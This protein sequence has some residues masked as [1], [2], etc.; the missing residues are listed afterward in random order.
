MHESLLKLAGHLG[1]GIDLSEL[2]GALYAIRAPRSL[3]GII[4]MCGQ[5]QDWRQKYPALNLLPEVQ[6]YARCL[7]VL[8]AIAGLS[9]PDDHLMGRKIADIKNPWTPLFGLGGDSVIGELLLCQRVGAASSADF[10]QVSAWLIW[11]AQRFHARTMSRAAYETYLMS[12]TIRLSKRPPG[13]RLYEAWL[14]MR[15]LAAPGDS[16]RQKLRELASLTMHFSPEGSEQLAVLFDLG[17]RRMARR[18]RERLLQQAAAW[19]PS[20]DREQEAVSAVKKIR[21]VMPTGIGRLLSLLWVDRTRRSVRTKRWRREFYGRDRYRPEIIYGERL[22]ELLQRVDA[23]EVHAGTVVEFYPRQPKPRGGRSGSGESAVDD[24]PEDLSEQ[25]PQLSIFLADGKELIRGYYASEGQQNGVEYGNAMLRWSNWTLSRSAIVAVV[26]LVGAPTSISETQLDRCARLAIGLTLLTGRSLERVGNFEIAR[27]TP[28]VSKKQPVMIGLRAH[29][30]YLYPGEPDLRHPPHETPPLCHP[31]ANALSL[32]LPS[33]WWALVEAI[34]PGNRM[35]RRRVVSR[36]RRALK[37]LGGKSGRAREFRIT[38]RG[39]RHAFIRAL[40]ERTRGDLGA[41]Q[42][43]TDDGAVNARNIIHYASYHARRLESQWRAA[44]ESLVGVLPRGVQGSGRNRYVGAQHAFD[45]SKLAKY[46]RSIKR[47]AW[48]AQQKNDWPRLFNLMTLYLS[49]WLGL[50]VAGR[51]TL[52]PVP[53][54]LIDD[55]WALVMDKH[56]ID[57]STDRLVP[58]SGTLRDQIDA[59]V[60]FAS[61]LSITAPKLDPIVRTERG[62]E[63]RLQYI[64][65]VKGVVPYRPKY[66]ERHEHL[67]SLPANWGRKVLRSVSS[68]LPGRYRDAEMGHWVRGRHAWDATS[69]FDAADFRVSWL[70]LQTRMEKRLGFK[71]IK[72]VHFW[73]RDRLSPLRP[74]TSETKTR[75]KAK[76]E[77][78]SARSSLGAPPPS[79]RKLDIVDLLREVDAARAGALL[80]DKQQLLPV[81]ALDLVRR[82]VSSQQRESV[83]WQREVAEAACALVRD[84]KQIP[85]FAAKPRPLF[86]NKVVLSA[87]ALQT[88]AYM[89][90]RVL[91]PFL[92]DLTCLPTRTP[93]AVDPSATSC[94]DSLRLSRTADQTPACKEAVEGGLRPKGEEQVQRDPADVPLPLN[95][96]QADTAA[97]RVK[98]KGAWEIELGRLAMV[99]IWRLGL[100]RWRLIE[101]WLRSVREDAPVLAQGPNR[102]MVVQV[103]TDG[104][105]E[106]VRRTVFLDAFTSSY[107]AADR[108]WVRQELLEPLFHRVTPA[109]RRARVGRAVQAY[110]RF[111]GAGSHRITLSAMTAAAAQKIMLDSAPILAAYARGELHTWDLGDD[112]LRRLAKLEPTRKSRA[113]AAMELPNSKQVEPS[114]E[115]VPLKLL[116]VKV[117]IAQ[118]LRTHRSNYKS[119]WREV[120]APKATTPPAEAL[121]RQFAMWMVERAGS[122]SEYPRLSAH[123]RRYIAG[124]VEVV[125]FAVLGYATWDGGA[126]TID[127]DVLLELQEASR[128]EFPERLQHGAWFQFDR[129]LGDKTADH[130]GFEVE[131]LGPH[132]ERAVS[133]KILRADELG[134]IHAALISSRSNIGNAELRAS[135]Q[136]NF[137]LMATYGTRRS[138]SAYLRT[139]DLQQDLCRVQV[140]D[141][142]RLKTGWSDRVLP[143]DFAEGY[144]QAWMREAQRRRYTF[145]IDPAAGTPANPDNFFDK[146]NQLVKEVTGDISMGSHHL[147]HTLASR[148]VLTLLRK[149]AG[150]D[151]LEEDLPWIKDLMI[152]SKRRMHALLGAEG[153][154]GQGMR[155]VSA[156]VGHSHPTT[157]IRHYVHV[158]G[159]ALYGALRKTD[160][161]DISRSFENRISGKSTVQRW[162]MQA[163]ASLKDEGNAESQRRAINRAMR[164]RIEQRFHGKG[165]DYDETPR[166]EADTENAASD[167]ISLARLEQVDQSLRDGQSRLAQDEI[168]AYA[169]GLRWLASVRTGKKGKRHS[170]MRRHFLQEVRAGVWLP[171]PLAAGSATDAA[172][173][174]CMWLERLRETR[175]EDFSWFLEKWVHASE[176]ERGRIRLNDASEVDRASSLA[177]PKQIDIR[178]SGAIVPNERLRLTT[179]PIPRMRIK[180]RDQTGRIINRD[181]RA[182]RWVLSYVAAYEHSKFLG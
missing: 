49:Y 178:I 10:E 133:A 145:L 159:I 65:L 114:A 79:S 24:D 117:P 134:K 157:T 151:R 48:T 123:E 34:G 52:V 56:R 112:E 51:K 57:G 1:R 176:N 146:V 69:T 149:P 162:A 124:R 89:Q 61:A 113:C 41:Q 168:D 40:A 9:V 30:L 75:A 37:E 8:D 98:D 115:D 14:G 135:A 158:L 121:L 68:Q 86:T 4:V 20:A 182:T 120:L 64:D 126:G 152:G 90:Q 138:E 12:K 122:D 180:C 25:E 160:T 132:P 136:R 95:A 81:D 16:V 169:E 26:E 87:D 163:R 118:M 43:I 125:A 131:Q 74:A 92:A 107:L 93:S 130:A 100:S 66:Q 139:L 94:G 19:M 28:E 59:Y 29:R 72:P 143:L 111:L 3:S 71:V 22:T 60:T 170:D 141:G 5:F 31:K 39:V 119:Y 58:L 32:P 42:V 175:R 62:N 91:P 167:V 44:A 38:G 18:D 102:Y 173:V 110:L 105:R 108:E 46:F 127:G 161:L 53:N 76:A 104:A 67:T 6:N 156:M 63:L 179:K 50:G 45:V 15:R 171:R 172:A 116:D 77:A 35:A 166:S 150:L 23:D 96:Q 153:D 11:Q 83:E 84:K 2:I 106:V 70:E 88:L 154:A 147:R 140:Y 103:K 148:L 78:E 82:T 128:H 33:R 97:V 181:T 85:I 54:V 137:E 155:A 165:I 7:A 21:S 17:Y 36:A 174:L 47:R 99:A 142:R 177:D 164:D 73:K 55:G 27:E 144:T 129:F 80:D 109:Q 101:C 13:N